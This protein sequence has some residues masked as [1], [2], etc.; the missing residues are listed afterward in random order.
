MFEDFPD[1]VRWQWM[2]IT[3]AELARIRYIDYS[4]WIELSGGSRLAVDAAP[5]IA[6]GWLLSAIRARGCWI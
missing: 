3:P 6:P 1:D 4:Y 5:R 2:T